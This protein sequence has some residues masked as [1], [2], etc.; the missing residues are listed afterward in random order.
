[1]GILEGKNDVELPKALPEQA[2]APQP[3]AISNK[4][5]HSQ[6]GSSKAYTFWSETIR[7]SLRE[8]IIFL[9]AERTPCHFCGTPHLR[10]NLGISY[11]AHAP[12]S[13]PESILACARCMPKYP[14][15]SRGVGRPDDRGNNGTM[16]QLVKYKADHAEMHT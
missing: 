15:S 4:A 8:L 13:I 2:P 11:D 10:R 16:R 14:C 1:M 5:P 12:E 3:E 6:E 9:H 7:S